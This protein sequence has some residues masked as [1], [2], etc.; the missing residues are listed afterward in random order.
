MSLSYTASTQAD[1]VRIDM[2]GTSSMEE[3]VPVL[4]EAFA[5][6]AKDGVDALLLD[7]RQLTGQ[8]PTLTERF[9]LAN[10]V[11]ELQAARHPRIRFALL[12]H[13]PMIHPERFGEIVATNRGAVVKVFT[14]E[15][16]ALGWLL[17]KS[18][19]P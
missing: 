16:L 14:D 9:A 1:H 7:V 18:R 8:P 10:K 13:E 19:E 12:G 3:I 2:A 6:A 11:S 17:G 5:R 15:S 4:E